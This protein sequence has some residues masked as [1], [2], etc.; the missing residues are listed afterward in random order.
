MAAAQTKALVTEKDRIVEDSQFLYEV[1][2]QVM[3]DGGSSVDLGDHETVLLFSGGSGV[4]L[5]PGLLD[6]IVGQCMKKG[7][8]NGERTRRIEF[9][10]S[11]RS[12]GTFFD[13][14]TLVFPFLLLT[15][16]CRWFSSALMDIATRQLHHHLAPLL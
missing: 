3:I 16:I 10:W 4:T 6:D 11:V 13:G 14:T 15:N 5:I 2:V 1:P 7:R 8:M 9:A 12:F